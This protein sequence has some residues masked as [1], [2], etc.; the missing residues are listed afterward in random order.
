MDKPREVIARYDFGWYHITKFKPH[1]ASA[2]LCGS[3]VTKQR[4]S[5]KEV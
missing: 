3:V 2:T 4:L 1:T 5:S